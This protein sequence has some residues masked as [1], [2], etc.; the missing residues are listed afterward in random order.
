MPYAMQTIEYRWEK[1]DGSSARKGND[2]KMANVKIHE[3]IL[4]ANVE[5]VRRLIKNS[6]NLEQQDCN[7]KTPLSLATSLGK[8]EIVQALLAAG[9]VP[10]NGLVSIIIDNEFDTPEILQ[11]FIKAGID[12][13]ASLEDGETILMNAAQQGSFS[14]VKILLQV[15]ANPNI[16]SRKSNFALLKAANAR[17]QEIFE[18]LVPLTSFDLRVRASQQ[19][20]AQLARLLRI[21]SRTTV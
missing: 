7:Y 11:A 10:T 1:V 6:T 19:L 8:I 9:A 2:Y 4:N 14:I 15:N 16:V 5:E 20:P 3:A 17:H 21:D 18:Y 12:V 13:N